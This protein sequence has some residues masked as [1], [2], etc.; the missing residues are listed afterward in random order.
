MWIGVGVTAGPDNTHTHGTQARAHYDEG[1]LTSVLKKTSL[2]RCAIAT[3]MG[4]RR[5]RAETDFARLCPSAAHASAR[6]ST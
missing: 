2:D 6:R 1:S 4:A 3:Q 5:Q